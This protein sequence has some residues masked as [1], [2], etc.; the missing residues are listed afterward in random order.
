MDGKAFETDDNNTSYLVSDGGI[1]NLCGFHTHAF[2]FYII[3]PKKQDNISEERTETEDSRVGS[4]DGTAEAEDFAAAD[5]SSC[6]FQYVEQ[7]TAIYH[8]QRY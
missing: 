4:T 8:W 1:Q 6:H 2:V 7:H 5:E 3:L